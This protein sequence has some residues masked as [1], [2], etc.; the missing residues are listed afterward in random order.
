MQLWDLAATNEG[1][2]IGPRV[3]FSTSEARGVVIDLAQDEELGDH[4]V[5][6]R[7]LVQV[8]RGNVR[9]T[10]GADAAT[11]EQGTL[12]VFEPGEFTRCARCNRRGCFS[13]LLRGRHRGT[14][15]RPKP[16]TRTSFQLTRHSRREAWGRVRRLP[17][18]SLVPV[19]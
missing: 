17:S 8:L 16:R 3:L 10:S 9:C 1:I 13:C 18:K 15:T 2:R 6:E 14:T 4:H 7:A 5:R 12:I 19:G 11:C